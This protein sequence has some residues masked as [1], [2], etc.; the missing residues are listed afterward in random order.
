MTQCFLSF[1]L[2]ASVTYCLTF[3][4]ASLAHRCGALD[5]PQKRKVHEAPVPTWGGLGLFAGMLVAVLVV[6]PLGHAQLGMLAGGL[7]LVVTG[8]IDDRYDMPAVV[9]LAAQVAAAVTVLAFGVR[10]LGYTDPLTGEYRQL[11]LWH[12][13]LFTVL[14][15]VCITNTINL[16]DGLDGLAS[17]VSCLA[18]G[19][20]SVLALQQGHL[21]VAILAAA[22][23]GACLGFLRHNFNPARI[24]M[25]DTGS[26]M[27]GFL[28]ATIAVAG[29]VKKPAVAAIVVPVLVLGVP[30][31]DTLMAVIRR[32]WRRESIFRADKEHLHHRLL[33]LGLS[34]RQVV[35]VLYAATS[36]LCV[37]ALV[38]SRFG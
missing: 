5:Q 20:L 26:Q 28:L 6:S 9:K 17:G 1:L 15:I 11:A 25:G 18:A 24:F 37:V 21:A 8:L 29:T 35:L 16:I 13:W 23:S 10:I 7:L 4:V 2:A 36:V 38:L 33:N 27:L 19:T 34:Q 22:V 30:V 14:W 3:A 12:S 32:S 31:V